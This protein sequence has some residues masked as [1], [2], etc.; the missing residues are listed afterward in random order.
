MPDY[1]YPA[2]V[3]ATDAIHEATCKIPDCQ[4]NEHY[5]AARKAARAALDAAAPMLAGRYEDLLGCIWLYINWRYV[6]KQLTT[7]QKEMF[8]DAVEAW[9][10]RLAADDGEQGG[11]AD[12]WW[13]DDA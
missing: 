7:P 5:A 3:V 2:L 11:K 10:A 12:R 8:A 9:S 1:P 4:S 6:T 13:R